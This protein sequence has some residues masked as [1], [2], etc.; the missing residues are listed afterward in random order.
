MNYSAQSLANAWISNPRPLPDDGS[1]VADFDRIAAATPDAVA[2][3]IGAADG[4]GAAKMTYADL[5]GRSAGL[6]GRLAGL[7][8]G[9]GD[10]VGLA[11]DRSFDVVVG[12]LGILRAGGAYVP[13]DRASPRART[14]HL[15]ADAD[16]RAVAVSRDLGGC[17][18]PGGIPTV[19]IDGPASP[20]AAPAEEISGEAPAYVL[21]TSGS[22]GRPKGVV[23]PHRAVR[24]LVLN[25]DYAAFGP[26]RRVLQLASVAFDAATFEI[27]GPLLNGGTCVIY[28]HAGL[29]DP[30][31]LRTILGEMRITTLWLT[32]G[33]FN[34]LIDT[35]PTILAGVEELLIGGEALSVGHVR[36]GLAALSARLIN[37]YGPTEATTF[38]CTWPI[39]KDLPADMVSIPIGRPI[40]NTAISIRDEDGAPVVPGAA[41]ELYIAGAGLALGYLNRPDL[42]AEKFVAMRNATGGRAYRTGDI[43]R[44]REDGLV[45]FI[46]RRDG[47][48]KVAGHRVELGEIE[49]VFRDHPGVR[50]A[51]AAVFRRADGPDRIA[52]WTVPADPEAP[53]SD[54]TLAAFAAER[55]GSYMRPATY[56]R[57]DALP[58]TSAGKLDRAR[59]QIARIE[60]PALA[61]PFEAPRGSLETW[62]A[63]TW[64]ELIGV[65]RV[66]R[67]DRFFELGGTSLMVIRFLDLLRRERGAR[68]GVA[69]FFDRPTVEALALLAEG[70]PDP[71]TRTMPPVRSATSEERIAIVGMA[72]RFAGAPD[73]E[74]FW[75]LLSEGRSGRV[76]ISSED[77]IAAGEDPALLEEPDYVAAAYPLDEAE[78]FDAAFFGLTPR[79][80]QLM[81]PQQRIFLEAA[82]SALEDA[83]CDP[84]AT[85][86]RIGVFGGVGRNAYLLHNLMCHPDLRASAA[87]YS[88]LIGNER[89]F[90]SAHVAFR[91]GLRGPAITVQTACSTSGVAIHMAAESLRRME[92]D[93][94][95]AGGAK[96]LVPNRVGY[97]YIEGGPLSPD[98]FIRAFDA[99]AAGMVRGSGVAMIAL[100][101]LD[102]ALRDADHIR[103]VL[104]GSAINNDGDRRAGFTA[105]S[106][107]G[108]ADVI[109]EAHRR[110]GIEA[111]SVSLIEAHG[112]GTSLGDPIEVT[113]LT[114]A[115]AQTGA[116]EATCAIGSVK[117]NIGHLDAGATAAGLIKAVLALE[118]R[119][120]PPSLNYV[121]PNPGLG[122]E[123]S[124]FRVNDRLTDWPRID[125]PRRAGISSFGLGGTN[126]HILIEEAPPV[127]RGR[128][129]VAGP[130]LILLSA[131]TDTAL[132]RRCADL[133]RWLERHETVEMVDV[134]HTLRVGRRRF[135]RRLAFL[136]DDRAE[137]VTRLRAYPDRPETMPGASTRA[138][139]APV[140]FAFPGTGTQYR[141]MA[142][143]L[144][145]S[146]PV[147][148]AALDH[149]N[150]LYEALEGVSLTD[151]IFGDEADL[152]RMSRAM[153][154]IF[155]VEIALGR[156]LESW[157]VA[158][159][160]MI[161]HSL[162]EYAA[163]CLAGVFSLPDAMAAVH[164]RATLLETLPE[165]AML[166]V[167][168]DEADLSAR[169]GPDLD[170]AAINGRDRCV[171]SGPPAA[172]A[173]L[174][175]ALAGDGIASRRLETRVALHSAMVEPIVDEFREF[176]ATLKLNAPT[177]A[178]VSCV[179]GT[180]ITPREATDPA[181]WAGHL[182]QPVR[183][184]DGLA[185]LLSQTDGVLL[186]VGP[187]QT[188]G[189]FARHHPAR[190]AGHEI[191]ATIRHPRTDTDD[192]AFLLGMAGRLWL[193][194]AKLDWNAFARQTGAWRV[195][196]PT[197]PFE[198]K[199]HW[200]DAIPY[201]E[202]AETLPIPAPDVVTEA[203]AADEPPVAA[204]AMTRHEQ[205]LDALKTIIHD[206]SGIPVAEL[207]P[208]ATFLELGFDSLFLTQANAAIRKV[209]G[210]RLT[211]RQLLET[212]PG[213]DLLARHLDATLGDA[214][215]AMLTGQGVPPAPA[216]AG[217]R[218]ALL[219][220]AASPG[221]AEVVRKSS[222]ELTPEQR[223][224]IAAIIAETNRRTPEAKRRTQE[225]RSVLADP[226]TVQGFRSQWK[227][228]IYPILSD[229]AKGSKVW[230]VDGN[231][232]VDLVGG[233]GVTMLGHQPDFLVEAL[234]DQIDRTLAIGPQSV[235]AGETARLVHEMTG[236]ERVA[237]C[238][239][240]SEAV[241]AA[242]RM[243]RTVTGRSKIVKFDGHYHGI[244]DEMQVR[245]SGSGDRGITLPSAP[246]I[247]AEAVQNTVV[248]DY[249]SEEVFDYLRRHADEIACVLVEPIRSRN[250]D[251]QPVEYL[252]KLRAVT[253]EVG[254]PLLIDE[255]VTG[256]R[257]HPGGIQA[258]YDIRADLV[259]YGKVVGSG[260][261]IGIVTGSALYMDALDGGMW[262]FGDDSVPPADMTW[263]AGTFVR[264]PLSLAAAK[265]T[266]EHLRAA[267][268]GLQ[269]RL[270][271]RS[272]A[273]ARR[274]NAAFEA[275]S[276][277]IRV[278]Q[279]SSLLMVNF[280][281]H[282][283]YS[284]LL[285]FHL[286]NRGVMT[287]E[288]RPIFLS[289]AHD[290]ADLDKVHAAFVDS[291][292]ALIAVG[293]LD[294]R[295]PEGR[296]RIP[297][298][299]GQQEIWIFARFDPQANCSYNLCNTLR[300]EGELDVEA[301]DAALRDLC[302][303]HEALRSL[304]ERDGLMQV[305]K[306][307]IEIG[308]DLQEAGGLA[309]AAI[310]DSIARIGHEEVTTPFDLDRGPLLRA[311]LVRFA[312]RD[313]LML[314]TVH[315]VIADGWSCAILLRELGALYAA[316]R[317]GTPAVLPPAQQLDDFVAMQREAGQGDM[318][319]A[320]DYW[321]GLYPDGLSRTDFPADRPRP[322]SRSYAARRFEIALERPFV[323]GLR[324]LAQDNGTTL[325]ASLIGGFAAYVARLT[326][327]RDTTIGFS[328]AGQPLLGG[329]S[330]VGHCVSFLPLKLSSDLDA[331]FGE[332]LR[333]IGASV[334]DA[335]EHQTFDFVSFAQET[336]P[337][338]DADWAP[339]VSIG[340]NLDPSAKGVGFG[341][342][343][344][345]TG[346]IG[347][348]YENLDLFL[349]FAETGP[350]MELQCTFNTALFDT[351][352]MERRMREYL[353]LLAL[354]MAAPD[355][356]LGTLDIIAK[357]D[358]AATLARAPTGRF[359]RDA[360]I[361]GYFRDLAASAESA[362]AVQVVFPAR[363]AAVSYGELDRRSD[364]MAVVL[365]ARGVAAGDRVV[366]VLPRSIDLIV[367]LLGILKAGAVYVPVD[368]STPPERLHMTLADCGA[369]LTIMRHDAGVPEAA[370]ILRV[371]DIPEQP[372]APFQGAAIGGGAP[373]CI[374]YTS[375][376]TGVPKGVVVPHRAIARLVVDADY[377]RLDATRVI[378]FLSTPAFDASTFE[379]W[380]ALLNGGKL[381]VFEGC[382]VPDL[383][384]LRRALKGAGATTMWLTAALF[385]AIV[386][387]DPAVFEGLDDLLIGGQALSVEHVRRAQAALPDLRILNGYGPTEN[388]TFTCC[389]PIARVLP[390][391]TGSIAI[392][393]PIAGTSV[394][395]VDPA[396][397]ILP[398]GV[399]GELVTGGDGLALGY[400]NR[401]DLTA[402]SFSEGGD[403]PGQ[404]AG[405]RYRTGD[406]CRMAD[407]GTIAFLHRRDSQVKIRGFRIEPQEVEVALE[408]LPDVRSAAV[409]PV[410]GP[411]GTRLV[412][413]VV[414]AGA[415]I[416]AASVIAG[417]RNV[418]PRHLI[419]SDVKM[420]AGLPVTSNGKID[421]KA[422]A[423]QA[424]VPVGHA[425]DVPPATA[426]ERHL[427]E[428]WSDILRIPVTSVEHDFF[429]LGGHSLN[430]LR[431]FDSIARDF[432]ADLPMSSLFAHPTIRTLGCVIDRRP[433]D[434]EAFDPDAPW[435]NS[436]VI[437]PGPGGSTRPIF[438]A[439]GVGGNVNNLS[440][441]GASL[442]KHR[443]VIGFQARGV[444]G[445]RPLKTI[446][447]IAAENIYY[448]RRH[449][450]VGP[451]SLA[452]YSAGAFAAFEMARQLTAA[453]HAVEELIILDTYA[454]GF[455]DD[456]Q[457]DSFQAGYAAMGLRRKVAR[458]LGEVRR[459]GSRHLGRRAKAF[460]IRSLAGSRLVR[461]LVRDTPWFLSS[462]RALHVWY[463]EIHEREGEKP[464]AHRSGNFR[465]SIQ[466]TE[467]WFEA[468]R[469]YAGGPY[470][471]KASLV[472]SAQTG[473]W[474]KDLTERHPDLG[475]HRFFDRSRLNIHN[476]TADHIEM[477]QGK[478][479]AALAAF[480]VSRVGHGTG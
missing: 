291:A 344:V 7:G 16:L 6:A 52:L 87:E 120:I 141:G 365:R 470:A 372:D 471:G 367:S 79:E 314:L 66:G 414:A 1:I 350:D 64:R 234:R 450:I 130:H 238:N 205:I 336:S 355:A 73:L 70:T 429:E 329:K 349:N 133:A 173:A 137:A 249:G 296:R 244:F 191:L 364:A 84:R 20:R 305:V 202:A 369:N 78:G 125:G 347:R 464:L 128:Q 285:F 40:G 294:G 258:L 348:V 421:L 265:A 149:C 75:D 100:K 201:G 261:P 409:I 151:A 88:M 17:A 287:Y 210:V 172:V 435:D 223:G 307:K 292:K 339:L 250:P 415:G 280:T 268:P 313:H 303:R 323:A 304:P 38:A 283:D 86:D 33:L 81:D 126:A 106:V 43:V 451:Y 60:R 197:Y 42:T 299:I 398:R 467:A 278:E 24:R 36:K 97:R 269:A 122:L 247:P 90:P 176:V 175:E 417:L 424:A 408:A 183:F 3:E 252:R 416:S 469:R 385:D 50:D 162:G 426:T 443:P 363:A 110:A 190:T 324:R 371:E 383:P 446:E 302:D 45:E 220:S 159:Q 360:G 452:G 111:G 316:H 22:T 12:M 379:I 18:L 251:Y 207:D 382:G 254:I 145:A 170:I 21:Y 148:A 289:T 462:Q 262:S 352:T 394:A 32:S 297:M 318:R 108:Q 62:I 330:L 461:G 92:C 463:N 298:S 401:P 322:K 445:H 161:G 466:M 295:D 341:D 326:G 343:D 361:V 449:Q 474:E 333:G 139:S 397:R 167:P 229:R 454:P 374:L 184:A 117:T 221:I 195:P 154:A 264:H 272:A 236:M 274:L 473:L 290:D 321:V 232:Y 57:L 266:L 440:D 196:L 437:H 359:D 147:F 67:R 204:L 119:Q 150:V 327:V 49:A 276:V 74:A 422:L 465:R 109:A 378:P 325:F 418:L 164:R 5:A 30:E 270:N 478:D 400:W 209:F 237:F 135:E 95:L 211:A 412:A 157:G 432:G 459:N 447:E 281:R 279:F 53:P 301:L 222:D 442:G 155:A 334:L 475:W 72:G 13:L 433:E 180:W 242:V 69:D 267:G 34:S 468:S 368:V 136:A 212:T 406:I 480:I 93:I 255:I 31:R 143:G 312:P 477:V 439:G 142:R 243:A 273:L 77:M 235:L 246:G 358:L 153:P 231:E 277:P 476:T 320:R 431:L 342:L 319:E 377:V 233:Y 456:V 166:A 56:R 458:E 203:P 193:A 98:G 228:M 208:H 288:G 271:D 55:L 309:A 116:G 218:A 23:T 460:F 430:A 213:L 256:F 472:L 76:E 216:P 356:P 177:R 306:A 104:I 340:V 158:P 214:L 85:D 200:I 226:R 114:R 225:S 206:L 448:M 182:R 239:T 8:I 89:D 388:T 396:G 455:R 263:F 91:L 51:A 58:L 171:V 25:T 198:R 387:Q 152:E 310:A 392:G 399:P 39:P 129:P 423:E 227:E 411:D 94:A 4:V 410:G 253:R 479:G 328:A 26:D 199:R 54:A 345:A 10:R 215:P 217:G 351:A 438:I 434:T 11:T 286:R 112:T 101:R 121:S 105:P 185:T 402:A 15:L 9:A 14:D 230:D 370:K 317:T 395:I 332:H 127:D 169:L 404:P 245:G 19:P 357:E 146:E 386:D 138:D 2:L 160:G 240:G 219:R 178:F 27:W 194:G 46:G 275:L 189:T 61:Q 224:H 384:A 337:K 82:W 28:P 444:M 389:H 47:Q 354:G 331:G 134:A 248:L 353:R 381:A 260:L 362:P 140:F 168:M 436:I 428:V 259:T 181:Y 405:R 188:L 419:P 163:A 308:I 300:L 63:S 96:V 407:D 44:M 124:P 375:G 335:L 71:A 427:V 393:R 123:K 59:L 241:L 132:A 99:Q 346:S 391:E 113:A 102:D 187:G 284:S 131:R 282:Q 174:A 80:V 441:M 48:V 41:G 425:E 420:L 373:A 65:D 315:H 293:L 186:E 257:S 192:R 118:H 380:G 35:D 403:V 103:A 376:S 165:G 156:L 311:R 68:I 413:F 83:G 144:Y 338:R 390:S 115:F 29:P 366:V 107:S 179:T 457:M 453:G 37:G